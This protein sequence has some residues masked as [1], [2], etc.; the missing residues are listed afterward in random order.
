MYVRTRFSLFFLKK[1]HIENESNNISIIGIIYYSPV[2]NYSLINKKVTTLKCFFK[3][4][5]QCD[6]L[7]EFCSPA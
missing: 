2:F 5:D 4:H 7:M 3:Y 6:I 1:T